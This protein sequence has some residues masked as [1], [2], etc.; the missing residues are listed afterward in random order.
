MKTIINFFTTLVLIIFL[1]NIN[2]SNGQYTNDI[3]EVYTNITGLIKTENVVVPQVCFRI[4][5]SL[6]NAYLSDSI[7]I[8]ILGATIGENSQLKVFQG[9][10][11]INGDPILVINE[12]LTDA[13]EPITIKNGMVILFL[14]SVSSDPNTPVGD[15]L[16]TVSYASSTEKHLKPSVVGLISV[17]V[18]FGVPLFIFSIIKC[19]IPKST[20]KEKANSIKKVF[21]WIS[22][23]LGLVFLAMILSRKVGV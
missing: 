3:C 1:L 15:C 5:P 23:I 7:T 4:V 6:G 12:T 16:L 2:N 10:D 19:L 8:N 22:F 20:K 18:A 13:L 9:S 14:D 21:F 17:A 11:F